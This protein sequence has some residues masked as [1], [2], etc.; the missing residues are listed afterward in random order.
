MLDVVF[1]STTTIIMEDGFSDNEPFFARVW[2]SAIMRQ[3][4]NWNQSSSS[5]LIL[6]TY[7]HLDVFFIFSRVVHH[8]L[9]TWSTGWQRTQACSRPS[10]ARRSLST[11]GGTHSGQ[12]PPPLLSSSHSPSF[13]PRNGVKSH[14]GVEQ[15]HELNLNLR[16][17]LLWPSWLDYRVQT[18]PCTSSAKD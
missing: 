7:E 13:P 9:R 5:L 16:F 15:S 12:S 6:F 1:F 3:D 8:T 14:R 17:T 11:V 2:D 10:H 18:T 4:N